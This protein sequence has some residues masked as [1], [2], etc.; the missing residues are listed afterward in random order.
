MTTISATSVNVAFSINEPGQL[1]YYVSA[2]PSETE[3]TIKA[4]GVLF[5]YQFAGDKNRPY[6]GLTPEASYY[7]HLV[8]DD[9]ASPPNT[10]TVVSSSQFTMPAQAAGSGTVTISV[11]KR[12]HQQVAPEAVFFRAAVSATGITEAT[13]RAQYDESWSEV[14]YVWSF[15]DP[16]AAS[17][18]VVNL[19]TSFN[20]FDYASG[21]EVAHVFRSAGTYTVTCTAYLLDGTLIGSDTQSVTVGSASS[22]WTGTDT[23]LLDPTGTG[24]ANFSG[25][26]VETTWT[27]AITA[28]KALAG[29]GRLVIMDDIT[30]TPSTKTNFTGTELDNVYIQ[31]SGT[32]TNRPI[33][34]AAN[35]DLLEAFN[36][37]DGD[38]V[39]TG[40]D[41]QGPYDSV[42]NTGAKYFAFKTVQSNDQRN[43]FDD[44]LFDGFT[45]AL[46]DTA[47]GGVNNET[48][49]VIHN[50]EITNWFDMGYFQQV[51]AG[52]YTG[53]IGN[54][55]RQPQQASGGGV[56]YG[57]PTHGP[58]RLESGGHAYIAGN[59]LFSRNGWV[60]P[61]RNVPAD[62][63]C[64]RWA[65]KPD[66]V[67]TH[68]LE[69][70]SGVIERN[71]MEGGEAMMAISDENDNGIY[72]GNNLL[73]QRNLMV[74][75]EGTSAFMN[76]GY[77]G[78]TVRD[79]VLIRPNQPYRW[80]QFL[81]FFCR[82]GTNEAGD[83]DPSFPLYIYN[84]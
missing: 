17:D 23:I 72:Y 8:M 55:I 40:I 38:F 50:C 61:P 47:P 13:S 69:R 42:S 39:V 80:I 76:I 66:N 24:H 58:F 77:G 43:L 65:T 16:G 49:F 81:G 31:R 54:R 12:S 1:Y 64:I 63:P 79:N 83:Q 75:T 82:A 2:N 57:G 70:P 33:I 73:V 4:N 6:A 84:N 9:N 28:L 7:V 60:T 48:M 59:D 35:T 10:S 30:V 5:N 78:T 29:T 62:Q 52:Q 67:G 25:A 11:P 3:A 22:T 56:R 19:P 20:D 34:S 74:G 44:C 32:G 26:D 53:I 45:L 15:G 51:N 46:W 18:K 21:K 41:F 71:A 36:S 27:A 37:F 14:Y 68:N